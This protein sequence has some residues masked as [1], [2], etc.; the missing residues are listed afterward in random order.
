VTSVPISTDEWEIGED[1]WD[2][3]DEDDDPNYDPY[4]H[5]ERR[6]IMTNKSEKYH[7]VRDFSDISEINEINTP[8]QS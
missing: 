8:S 4:E 6:L 2:S 1:Y 5:I 3:A 7:P